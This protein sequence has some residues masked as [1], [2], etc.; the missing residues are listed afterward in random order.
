MRGF[1]ITSRQG[2]TFVIPARVLFR[3]SSCVPGG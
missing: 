3:L 2:A 1:G